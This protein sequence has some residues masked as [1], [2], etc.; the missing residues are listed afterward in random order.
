MILQRRIDLPKKRQVSKKTK[1]VTQVLCTLNNVSSWIKFAKTK[2][3]NDYK[4]MLK[5]LVLPEP[6]RQY[7]AIV[8][9]Y[10]IVRHNKSKLDKDNVVFGLKWLADTLQE[11][12]YVE[13]DKVVNFR[14]FDTIIDTSLEETMFEIRLIDKK[15]IW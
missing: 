3:K 14:S 5:E 9:E 10:R 4:D 7:E 12:G 8:I 13:D 6:E 2:I 1:K 11:L 15:E